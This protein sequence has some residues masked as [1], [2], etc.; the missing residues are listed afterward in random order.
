MVLWKCLNSL[1]YFLVA[2]LW[3][4]SFISIANLT[5]ACKIQSLKI[6]QFRQGRKIRQ[7]LKIDSRA[8][9]ERGLE[10]QDRLHYISEIEIRIYNFCF[11]QNEL[12]I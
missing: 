1:C 7:L 10:G 8:A 11:F 12:T 3:D 5:G 6:L 2:V 9:P 4:L